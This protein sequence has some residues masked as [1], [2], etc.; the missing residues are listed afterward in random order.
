MVKRGEKR[1]GE[2]EEN[3]E[4]LRRNDLNLEDR[5]DGRKGQERGWRRKVK[6]REDDE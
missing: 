2:G 1:R 6:M 4:E 3:R 5:K